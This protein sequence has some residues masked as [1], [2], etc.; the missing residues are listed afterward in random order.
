MRLSSGLGLMRGV[1]REGEGERREH[2]EEQVE[3]AIWQWQRNTV[4]GLPSFLDGRRSAA[5]RRATTMIAISNRTSLCAARVGGVSGARDEHVV[6]P[7]HL[8]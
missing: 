3:K 1:W 7:A 6:V 4:Q 8:D 5:R 2:A